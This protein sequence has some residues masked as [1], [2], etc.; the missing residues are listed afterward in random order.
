MA[1]DKTTLP[2]GNVTAL[3]GA[4]TITAVNAYRHGVV[5]VLQFSFS[6]S[7][8]QYV[9]FNSTGGLEIGGGDAE[10]GSGTKVNF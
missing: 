2:S 3:V 4:K 7:S 1:K 5:T 8:T 6:D 10:W 9:K